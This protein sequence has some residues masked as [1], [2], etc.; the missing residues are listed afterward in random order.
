[1]LACAGGF[2]TSLLMNKML[3]EA[4]K[5]G[6]EVTVNAIGEKIALLNKEINQIEVRGG[7]ANE[8]RDERAMLLDELL[9]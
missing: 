1:M 9:I 8:L 2:S 6:V 7:Y 5:R 4:K 3:D